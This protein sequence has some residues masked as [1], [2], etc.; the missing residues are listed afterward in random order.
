VEPEGNLLKNA[1]IGS[2]V[3]GKRYGAP[4]WVC[5]N[6][7]FFN[8]SDT[9][10]RKT[11][12]LADLVRIIGRTPPKNRGLAIDLMGKSTLGEVSMTLA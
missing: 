5:G 10:I 12:K 6:F 7:L 11:K 4:H 2:T 9:Q 1:V 3:N 8:S